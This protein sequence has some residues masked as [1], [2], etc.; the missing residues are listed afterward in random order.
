[1]LDEPIKALGAGARERDES[2]ERRGGALNPLDGP[3]N[4]Q[5]KKKKLNLSQPRPSFSSPPPPPPPPPPQT[6]I[7]SALLWRRSD[8]LCFALLLDGGEESKEK[9]GNGIP[10]VSA[11]DECECKVKAILQVVDAAVGP[12]TKREYELVTVPVGDGSLGKVV[13]FLGREVD[14]NQD[15]DESSSSSTS[16]STSSS[17]SPPSLPGSSAFAP[18]FA[19]PPTMDAR[20]PISEPLHTGVKGIDAL[21]PV[22]RGQCLLVLGGKGSGK[23]TA[24]RDAA[25][26]AARA[27]VRVSWAAV[28]AGEGASSRRRLKELVD[29]FARA[30]VLDSITIVSPGFAGAPLGLRYAAVCSAAALGERARDAGRHALLVVDDAACVPATWDSVAEELAALGKDA[31]DGE[32]GKAG[33]EKKSPRDLLEAAADDD[34]DDDGG[35]GEGNSSS[36]TPPGKSPPRT[37]SRERPWSSTKGC[38][39]PPPPQPGGAS[40]ARCCR[41]RPRCLRR[42]VGAR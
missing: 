15:D 31:A 33:A 26:A 4:E 11:G 41:G 10:C 12:T 23:T 28:G 38:S 9:E 29:A 7:D 39:S 18:L 8:N 35:G 21:T 22:G 24:C 6:H 27:G 17:S 32:G 2:K 5:K 25:I 42:G 16:T 19:L 3:T 14:L 13:D 37:A 20:E 30:D 34:D 40:W 36:S 1:M